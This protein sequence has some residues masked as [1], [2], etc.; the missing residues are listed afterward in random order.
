M[1]LDDY[2]GLKAPTFYPGLDICDIGVGEKVLIFTSADSRW[3]L[4]PL[5]Q[6]LGGARKSCV[7]GSVAGC[8]ATVLAV[9]FRFPVFK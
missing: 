7:A 2:P 9:P 8:L 4:S 1:P 6:W 5:W 3:P